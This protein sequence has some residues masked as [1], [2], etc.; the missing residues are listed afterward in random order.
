MKKR[1]QELGS[2]IHPQTLVHKSSY[3]YLMFTTVSFQ[4]SGEGIGVLTKDVK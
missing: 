4:K 1:R 3:S 2:I